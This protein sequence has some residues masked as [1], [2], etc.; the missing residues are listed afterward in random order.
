MD[1]TNRF[2][3]NHTFP[4]PPLL[5]TDNMRIEVS[6]NFVEDCPVKRTKILAA[7]VI[8]LTLISSGC[9]TSD[10]VQ[11]V[12]LSATSGS[13]GGGVYNIIGWGGTLQLAVNANYHS[14][15]VVPVTDAVTYVVTPQG[16]DDNGASLQ[17][18]PNTVTLSTTGMMT[19]VNPTVCTWTDEAPTSST[20]SW[21]LS[22]SYQVVANYKGMNS[23]PVFV[24]IASAA[25]TTDQESP[26][27]CGPSASN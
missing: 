9:G 16:T 2:D 1:V 4:L 8:A 15:K 21:F 5:E 12:T 18:P 11:S 22:G 23:Q 26:G 25:G 20:P 17:A 19:A 7:A 24:A 14:G 3:G 13:A 27:A 10:Y 6:G